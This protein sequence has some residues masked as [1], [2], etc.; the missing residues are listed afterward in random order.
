MAE[1]SAMDI[2]ELL[3]VMPHRFPMLMLDKIIEIDG[4][5]SAIG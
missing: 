4:D 1:L 3:S 5:D 2:T